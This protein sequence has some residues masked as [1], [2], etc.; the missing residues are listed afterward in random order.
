LL[1]A[2]ALF[3][4]GATGAGATQAGGPFDGQS[5]VWSGTGT[6]TFASG[7]RES[8]RCRV[9]Y[10]QNAETNLQQALRCASDSY[11]FDINAYF[12]S[13][14]GGLTGIW[15]E[16]AQNIRGTVTG[17]V[18]GGRINGNLHGPGFIAQLAVTTSGNRQTVLIQADL[19]E[20]QSVAIEVRK[21][22]N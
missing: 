15:Q 9:Q 18:A 21:A 10:V 20:I 17:S 7:A 2:A 16:L 12:D 19:E 8:L 1:A 4:A 3:L 11:R 6:L 14:N 5:G 13:I 22:A